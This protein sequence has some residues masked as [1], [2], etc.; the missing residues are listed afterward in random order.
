[1]PMCGTIG[2]GSS[3]AE[4]RC[5]R[6]QGVF[7]CNDECQKADWQ[8]HK[9]FC[10]PFA[11]SVPV[12]A[13]GGGVSASAAGQ[14]CGTGRPSPLDLVP[15]STRALDKALFALVVSAMSQASKGVQKLREELP[16]ITKVILSLMSRGARPDVRIEAPAADGSTREWT[17][18]GVVIR[19]G[20]ADL[21]PLLQAFLGAVSRPAIDLHAAIQADDGDKSA[22]LCLAIVCGLP[23]VVRTLIERGVDVRRPCRQT[24]NGEFQWP[25]QLLSLLACSSCS[26][27]GAVLEI[28]D[29][30]IDAGANVNAV[31]MNFNSPEAQQLFCHT[32]LMLAFEWVGNTMSRSTPVPYPK[33]YIVRLI[34]NGAD[35]NVRNSRM[36][37]PLDIAAMLPDLRLFKALVAGGADPLPTPFH[38]S[39]MSRELRGFHYLQ[40]AVQSDRADVLEAAVAAGV[41]VLKVRTLGPFSIP[42]LGFAVMHGRPACVRFLLEHGA[43][44]NEAYDDS[45]S[46][47]QTPL[48]T[49][50]RHLQTSLIRMLRAA[51]GKC[52]TELHNA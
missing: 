28:L 35:L 20:Q 6:C 37:R 47:M 52:Y 41:R 7:Y 29:L 26:P 38:M 19:S 8:R 45:L 42:L 32:A 49:A 9:K 22:A 51:G 5:A 44:V 4:M 50:M 31:D 15:Q 3:T 10:K 11:H 17:A 2:C 36:E 48:D 23:A 33:D 27:S 24:R 13:A 18:I 1:M 39:G 46:G 40:F 21:Q 43:D 25:L 34:K 14:A 16:A 30:L 12:R